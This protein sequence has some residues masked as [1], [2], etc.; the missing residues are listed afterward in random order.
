MRNQYNEQL[1]TLNEELV[2][3]GALCESGIA[4]AMKAL[5]TGDV[6]MVTQ[7][8]V[9]EKQIDEKE[10]AIEAMCV[11]IILNQQPVAHDLMFV[12]AALK[13]ITDME[14]IG[15]QAA[16]IA[17]FALE[18]KLPESEQNENIIDMAHQVIKMVT[19]SVEAFVNR[20]IDAAAMVKESDNAVDNLFDKIKAELSIEV[21]SGKKRI[22]EALDILMIIKYLERIGDH[23]VNIAEW[24][25]FA[26]TGKHDLKE[27]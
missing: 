2:A 12:S 19:D 23:A 9:V 7:T 10:S 11:R 6:E 17:D 22:E 13:M 5:A 21:T 15:D 16:D 26:M 8:N 3:M 24:V 4:K 25:E 20:D 14:R 1:N 18:I 27:D